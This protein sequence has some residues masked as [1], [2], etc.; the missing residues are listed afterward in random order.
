MHNDG[1]GDAAEVTLTAGRV[2]PG[3]VAPIPESA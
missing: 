1:T 2:E 3:M